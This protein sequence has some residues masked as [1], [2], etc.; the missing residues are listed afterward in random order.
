MIYIF[1]DFITLI[2]SILKVVM[3][4]FAQKMEQS[5]KNCETLDLFNDNWIVFLLNTTNIVI[6][7]EFN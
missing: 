3:H 1:S 7:L 4:N 2:L 5:M 6:S